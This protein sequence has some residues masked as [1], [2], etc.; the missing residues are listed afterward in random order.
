MQK[1]EKQDFSEVVIAATGNPWAYIGANAAIISNAVLDANQAFANAHA[2]A[3]QISSGLL[4]EAERYQ[5]ASNLWSDLKNG[6]GVEL[7]GLRGRLSAT[8]QVWAD[9][10][11][12]AMQSNHVLSDIVETKGTAAFADV[13]VELGKNLGGIVAAAQLIA[14]LNKSDDDGNGPTVNDV[15]KAALGVAAGILFAV[16]G[17]LSLPAI[18]LGILVGFAV[19]VAWDAFSGDYLSEDFKSSRFWDVFFDFYTGNNVSGFFP[20]ISG[21]LTGNPDPLVKDIKYV[22]VDPL[23]LDLDGDGLEITPLSQ[24]VQFDGNGD[25]IRTNTSWIDADDGLLAL[26]RNGNGVIDSGRELFGDETLLADGKKAA[27]GFAALAELDVGGA[28][29]ATGGAGDGVFDAKDAQY[30][31][32]RIWRDLNQDGISQA[33][34][35]QTLAEAGIASIKLDSTKTSTNY[36]DAQLVQSGSFTRTDG[37]EGQAGSFILAQ[38]NAV[39]THAP[40]AISAE[41]Q[42]LPAIQGSG[43]VRDLQGAATLKPQLLELFGNVQGAGS[44]AEFAVDISQLLM[45]WGNDNDYITASEQ[46]LEEDGVGLILRNPSSEKETLWMPVAIQADKETREAFRSA[47]SQEDR[48]LFDGMRASMVGQLEK[49]YAYEAFTGYTFLRWSDIE[50]RYQP[51]TDS[52]TTGR[53]VTVDMPLSQVIQERAYGKEASLPGYRIVVIPEPISGMP[54]IDMLWKRLVEDATRNL[55]PALRLSQY[56]DM[57]QLNVSE[58]GVDL[59]FSQMDAALDAAIAADGFEGVA[60]FLDIYRTY[61]GVFKSA[62][63]EGGEKLRDLMQAGAGD[64]TIRNAFAATGLNLVTGSSQGS[65]NDDSFAGDDG[66]N[67][68]NG[69]AGDDFIDGGAG[70]DN[71]S[72]SMGNDMVLGGEGA[73]AVYGG[74]GNDTL[75]GGAGND[76]LFGGGGS[77]TILGGDG[78][79]SLFAAGQY[80]GGAQGGVD[81]LDGGAGNDLLYGGFGSQTYLFGR[82][83]GQD[84][85]TNYADV[86]SG[87][88]DP[89]AG[90]QDVLKFKAG[91]LVSDVLVSRSGDD[92]VLKISGSTDQVTVNGYFGADGQSTNTLEAIRFEDGTSWS[93]AQVKAMAQAQ[94]RSSVAQP[95]PSTFAVESEGNPNFFVGNHKPFE[96]D[97]ETLVVVQTKPYALNSFTGTFKPYEVG[98]ADTLADA[99]GYHWDA[100]A[101]PQATATLDHQM[102]QLLSAMAGFA[103]ASA[104][105]TTALDEVHSRQLLSP[106]IASS[107]Q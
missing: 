6:L 24:G 11:V 48:D 87:Q 43:W 81:S 103:P 90:K 14:E 30:T 70:D 38:N 59:D 50:P 36:G 72:G 104:G 32:V 27:H 25:T 22:M 45:E 54:H 68:F 35:M 79:D 101:A 3:N 15:T 9:K 58:A 91:V 18:G 76:T 31:N 60:L 39:T 92:L 5:A 41:A 17:G 63:W 37:S 2:L 19:D 97:A 94:A 96:L 74:D 33:G 57:V 56:A 65:V 107:L 84:T 28:A 21:F 23:V 51:P 1:I 69:D 26:D 16:V 20:A 95:M 61:G 102:Q 77:D 73:D 85:I 88:A 75:D 49:L 13:L 105:Q 52:A 7:S 55:M 99:L 47:L 62:G 40:I 44:R 86:W 53:P 8:E 12:D 93:Y 106:V 78:D 4:S 82:G 64:E 67:T 46:A 89:T 98:G 66:G 83:D 34:E 80:G 100:Q 42:A 10:A 29:N 71:L